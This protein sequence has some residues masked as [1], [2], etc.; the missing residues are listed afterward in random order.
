MVFR[1]NTEEN[2]AEMSHHKC[3]GIVLCHSYAHN[4]FTVLINC[5]DISP[6]K[7][8]G[9]CNVFLKYLLNWLPFWLIHLLSLESQ[10]LCVGLL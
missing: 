9:W 5:F 8:H 6:N 1:E 10:D 4:I 3:S 7:V 2:Y